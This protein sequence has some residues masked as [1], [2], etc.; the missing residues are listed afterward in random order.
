V[1]EGEATM[2]S[3][4]LYPRSDHFYT[5]SCYLGLT[6]AFPHLSVNSRVHHDDPSTIESASI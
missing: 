1:P 2:R 6:E 3:A 5:I 4:I